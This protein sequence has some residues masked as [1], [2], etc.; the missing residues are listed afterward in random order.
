MS[1]YNTEI[2]QNEYL[3]SET[4][5]INEEKENWLFQI[6]KHPFKLLKESSKLGFNGVK[7][8]ITVI[9]LFSV[10]NL[11]LLFYAIYVL[12]SDYSSGKLPYTLLVLIIG[13]AVTIFAVYK[14]YQYIILETLRSLYD[15]MTPY[16]EGIANSIIDKYETYSGKEV[17]LSE[18]QLARTLNY[19][20]ILSEKY[21]K[22]PSLLRKSIVF[23][24]NR[25]P[26]VGILLDLS[27]N[28][29]N[30]TKE[31]ASGILYSR[32]NSYVYD[33]IFGN[34]NMKWIW[35][36]LPLNIIIQLVLIYFKIM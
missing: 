2:D 36:L 33:S 24:L 18:N 1:E 31:E 13:I 8:L 19:G 7:K 29:S 30:S 14:T 23:L 4:N 3:K 11:L 16:V 20:I 34:N 9:F 26:V 17:N 27:D 22:M 21:Q 6:F 15:S 32:I 25:I 5:S 12:R 28:M 35:W 10:T